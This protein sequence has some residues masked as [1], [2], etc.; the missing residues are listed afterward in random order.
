MATRSTISLEL[1]DGTVHQVY[2][3]FDGYLSGVGAEL[4]ANFTDPIVLKELIDKGD[5]SAIGDP[6][7]NRGEDCPACTF[8][9]F[10]DYK[11]NA[12]FEEYNYILRRID[13]QVKWFVNG[14]TFE[15]LAAEEAEDFDE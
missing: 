7:S 4:Q 9:N 10:A 8:K 14:V 15:E 1:D 2:C 5:M 3:H 11:F 12:A 6:Y 13:G